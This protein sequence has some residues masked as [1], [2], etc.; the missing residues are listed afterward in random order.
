M[1]RIF[2]FSANITAAVI[3]GMATLA[4]TAVSAESIRLVRPSQAESLS[5]DGVGMTVYYLGHASPLEIVATFGERASPKPASQLRMSLVD[6]DDIRFI[7][8]G[9]PDVSFQF[10]R[11]GSVIEVHSNPTDRELTTTN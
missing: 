1:T 7:I 3:V 10:V 8:P 6:G 2:N 4:A 11:A 5:S 9:R